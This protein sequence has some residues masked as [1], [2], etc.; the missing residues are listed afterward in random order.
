MASRKGG[1]CC[2]FEIRCELHS[3]LPRD[4]LIAEVDGLLTPLGQTCSRR[5][6][7]GELVE[8]PQLRRSVGRLRLDWR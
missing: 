5:L 2:L 8:Q 3:Q 6:V 7:L 4:D 1:D